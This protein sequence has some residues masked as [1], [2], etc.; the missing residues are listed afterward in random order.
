[1]PSTLAAT[2]SLVLIEI[3]EYSRFSPMPSEKMTAV[4]GSPLT[5]SD[6]SSPRMNPTTTNTIRITV[7]RPANVSAVR[8][9]RRNRLRIAYSQGSKR[10]KNMSIDSGARVEQSAQ[11]EAESSSTRENQH[12]YVL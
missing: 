4:C 7:V 8:S 11:R 5:A 12:R 10:K 3:D 1:M 9:G 6:A 2:R